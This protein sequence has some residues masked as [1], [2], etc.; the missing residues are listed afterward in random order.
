MQAYFQLDTMYNKNHTIVYFIVHS[1]IA[2]D[3]GE[4]TNWFP[5]FLFMRIPLFFD[6]PL[7]VR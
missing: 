7:A 6:T 2:I 5:D 1:F 3:F 4:V